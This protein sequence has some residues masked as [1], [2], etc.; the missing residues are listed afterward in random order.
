MDDLQWLRAVDS[1]IWTVAWQATTFLALGLAASFALRRRPARAHQALLLAMLGAVAAPALTEAGRRLGLG[2]W[3]EDSQSPVLAASVAAA[4]AWSR[5]DVGPVPSP[6]AIPEPPRATPAPLPSAMG[7]DAVIDVADQQS[8]PFP[9]RTLLLATWGAASAMLLIRLAASF[10][11][12]RGLVRRA[13]VVADGAVD[14]GLAAAARGLGLDVTP[15]I[16]RSTE[17]RCPVIWCWGSRPL[18]LMPSANPNKAMDQVAVFRHELAHWRRRD[19]LSTLAAEL[20]VVLLPWHPLAW[21]ARARLGSLAESACDDWVLA[22]GTPAADYAAALLGLLPQPYS[23]ALAA[24]S[25]RRGLRQRIVRILSDHLPIPTAGPRWTAA[26]CL[27]ML[28]AA[29]LAALAQARPVSPTLEEPEKAGASAKID[30]STKTIRGKVLGPDG[31][32]LAGATVLQV[33]AQPSKLPFIALPRGTGREIRTIGRALTGADGTFAM[34]G[35]FL[36]ADY[37]KLDTFYIHLVARHPGTGL[38]SVFVK[39]QDLAEGLTLNLPGEQVVRGRLLTSSGVPAEGV[40]VVLQDFGTGNSTEMRGDSTSWLQKD[41]YLP[42]YWPRSTLT[43]S[44]GRFVMEGLPAAMYVTLSFWHTDFA[45]DEVTVNTNPDQALSP[46]FKKYG[47]KP[48]EPTFEH[49]LEPARPV[50]GRVTDRATGAPLADVEMRV[51]SMRE[52]GGHFFQIRTD[53]N[54]RYRVSGH[55]ADWFYW[56]HA[57]PPTES[58]YVA[59]RDYRDLSKTETKSLEIDMA[60]DRGKVVSGR[61]LDDDGKSPIADAAVIYQAE[62]IG[63]KEKG[64]YVLD[65]SVVTD[66]DG[67]F[68]IVALPG[69]GFLAVEGPTDQYVRT[70][71]RRGMNYLADVHPHGALDVDLSLDRDA[72]PVEIELRKGKPLEAR[73]LDPDGRP[74]DAFVAMYKGIDAALV[75]GGGDGRPFTN[76]LFRIPNADPEKTY[77]VYLVATARRLAAVAELKLDPSGK[78]LE[79]RLQP[80]ATIKGKI[81]GKGP[82]FRADLRMLHSPMPREYTQRERDDEANWEFYS[83]VLGFKDFKFYENQPQPDGTFSFEAVIPGVGYQVSGRA[84]AREVETIVWNLKPGEVRDIGTLN[85]KERRKEERHD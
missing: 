15:G 74:M 51:S 23:P 29:S 1:L 37:E 34:S 61:V 31:K 84:G 67:W 71:R 40:R 3:A 5:P 59:M 66:G 42:D 68:Q 70:T 39:P 85:L 50:E 65:N 73:V 6:A 79:V 27:A 78:P 13:E 62:R 26:A 82:G 60:L 48:V 16:A 24:A 4:P 28:L 7:G 53:A 43:D 63:R 35:Q 18:L 54:G 55:M 69:K 11:A 9:W 80:S 33:G 25:G 75:H 38:L 46:E 8:R 52:R 10:V 56:V 17:V 47:I 14:E 44:D 81:E 64:E 2:L 58:G 41:E 57:Y 19:H 76:G 49:V 72:P 21:A 20:L 32:P 12:G 30:T 36:E 77:R 22:G 83:H 45:V